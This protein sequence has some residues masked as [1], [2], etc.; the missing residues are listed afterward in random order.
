[1][2]MRDLIFLFAMFP[3]KPYVIIS[4]NFH[5]RAIYRESDILKIVPNP[6]SKSLL[7]LQLDHV[8]T[9]SAKIKMSLIKLI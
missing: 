9:H 8:V 6:I 2:R 7:I 4:L 5:I 3:V 1:M